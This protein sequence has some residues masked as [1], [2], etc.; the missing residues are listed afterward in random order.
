MIQLYAICVLYARIQM[1]PPPQAD[2]CRMSACFA[3]TAR[4][5][6]RPGG[7]ASGANQCRSYPDRTTRCQNIIFRVYSMRFYDR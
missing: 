5:V 7:T 1:T 2:R 3:R 4:D 6:E